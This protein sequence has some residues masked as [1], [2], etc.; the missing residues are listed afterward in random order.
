MISFVA[1]IKHISVIFLLT[2]LGGCSYVMPSHVSE[3]ATAYNK[4][5]SHSDDG[6]MLLNIVRLRNLNAPVFLQIN[7]ITSQNS[8]QTS[9]TLAYSIYNPPSGGTPNSIS[10]GA[11]LTQSPTISYTPLQGQQFTQNMLSPVSLLSIYYLVNAGWSIDVVFRLALQNI[12]EYYNEPGYINADTLN[13]PKQYAQFI[14]IIHLLSQLQQSEDI[15]FYFDANQSSGSELFVINFHADA[16]HKAPVEALRK[17]LS[18]DK[19]ANS[20]IFTTDYSLQAPNAVPI[21]TRSVMAIMSFLANDVKIPNLPVKEQ[22]KAIGNPLLTIKY[23]K[24][25]PNSYTKMV[26]YYNHYYY[27]IEEGDT[28]SKRIIVLLRSLYELTA[29]LPGGTS[30]VVLSLPVSK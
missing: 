3:E 20:I 14:R 24:K 2:L 28:E 29:G 18:L 15:D 19:N 23:A 12:N 7:S 8:L 11:S 1:R 30:G 17:L 16:M 5:V 21:K 26:V 4:S 10:P 13:S 9:A 27:Y 22:I 25:S 6:Q